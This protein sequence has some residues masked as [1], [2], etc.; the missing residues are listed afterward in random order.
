MM[1]ELAVADRFWSSQDGLA[2]YHCLSLHTLACL[3]SLWQDMECAD[4]H[5][6]CP[7]MLEQA[8]SQTNAGDGCRAAAHSGSVLL[9]SDSCAVED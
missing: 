1:E 3:R 7:G 5:S 6:V 8:L 4:T 2:L 9:G